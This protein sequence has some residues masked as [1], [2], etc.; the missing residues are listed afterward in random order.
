[1]PF[2]RAV[3]ALPPKRHVQFRSPEGR[4]YRE[5]EIGKEGFSSDFAILYHNNAPTD[6][7]SID[8]WELPDQESR[9]NNPL[10]PRL[11]YTHKLDQGGDAVLSRRLLAANSD[12]RVSY[13]VADRPSPLYRNVSGDELY[14]V[15][16]GQARVE[17]VFGVLEVGALDFVVM[18]RAVIHRVVPVG[19]EPLRLLISEARGSV[20][21]PRRYLSDQGQFLEHSPYN[22]RDLRAPAEPFVVDEGGDV[23]VYVRHR[24]GGTRYTY[25]N[26][27]FDVVGWDGC[28]YPYA[29]DMAEFQPYTNRLHQ[30]PTNFQAFEAPGFVVCAAVPHATEYHPDAVPVPG[31]HT[32]VDSD[33]LLF[34]T[35]AAGGARSGHGINAGAITWHPGGFTH[36]PRAGELERA[37]AAYQPGVIEMRD[38]WAVMIDTFQPL[39]VGEAA[40][41]CEN[42]SY[43]SSWRGA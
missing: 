20:R 1:M 14:F 4:L 7:V 41:A 43:L 33:E 28:L 10:V 32:N 23:D 9:P 8:T 27:P 13:V 24:H 18:P 17:T 34:W 21:T 5:E 11:L 6:V 36:G 26:H 30:P 15:E 25:A 37:V 40:L 39:E 31:A 22:E 3:G 16:S 29:F 19:E 12:L 38:M 42:G 2:Y 35:E